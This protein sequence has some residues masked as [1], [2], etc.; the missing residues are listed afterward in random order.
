MKLGAICAHASI[1]VYRRIVQQWQKQDS[2]VML[3]VEVKV[4]GDV[5]NA[6]GGGGVPGVTWQTLWTPPLV[7][8]KLPSCQG[9]GSHLG[10]DGW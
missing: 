10:Q 7:A 6:D 9:L 2:K 8:P 5:P 1:Q 3:K 4:G